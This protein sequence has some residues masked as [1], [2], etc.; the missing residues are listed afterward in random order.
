ML[1]R[2]VFDPVADLEP[3]K[4]AYTRLLH[5]LGPSIL[6]GSPFAANF[7]Q[8]PT[9]ECLAI[10]GGATGGRVFDH[11]DPNLRLRA[12]DA[13]YRPELPS[14]QL[15]EFFQLMRHEQLLDQIEMLVG[16]EISCSPVFHTNIKFNGELKN[17]AQMIAQ[18]SGV[19]N[20]PYG[21]EYSSF[22]IGDT[23]WHTD[24]QNS[25][26]GMSNNIVTAWIPMEHA[27]EATS[28]LVLRAGSHRQ[29]GGRAGPT[30]S[31][32]IPVIA[33]PGDVVFFDAE[34]QHSASTNQNAKHARWAVN[35][36]YLPTGEPTGRPHLPGFVARSR[37]KPES[38]LHDGYTWQAMWGAA[39]AHLRWYDFP[40][41][42]LG[43]CSARW[44]TKVRRRTLPANAEPKDWLALHPRRPLHTLRRAP[45]AAIERIAHRLK[46]RLKNFLKV[47]A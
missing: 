6:L 43:Q 34:L 33:R 27:N 1:V 9:A 36:R 5:A 3:L 29:S 23:P 16:P 11:L 8:R 38:E 21:L 13:G 15:P 32:P 31:D 35:F 17:L 47:K 28:H 42:S 20:G 44:A 25:L 24:N 10:L 41:T 26:V 37:S 39:L 46:N 45:P 22:Y 12:R 30:A 19:R 4:R 14:A 2:D 18:S 7:P 40:P